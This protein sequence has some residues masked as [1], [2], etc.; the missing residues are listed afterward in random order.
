V[1]LVGLF[2]AFSVQSRFSFGLIIAGSM[3]AGWCLIAG[4]GAY[5]SVRQP[6][7]MKSFRLLLPV[8]V[9]VIG[10]P[11]SLWN[12]ID[13]KKPLAFE[14]AIA[15][16]ALLSTLLGWLLWRRAIAAL[17]EIDPNRS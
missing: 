7:E 6:T 13:W 14:L 3:Q 2:I 1:A 4:L 12:W 10:L 16:G 8:T 9:M 17:N 11:V 5:L 15:A